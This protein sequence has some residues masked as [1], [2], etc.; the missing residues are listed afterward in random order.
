MRRFPFPHAK[1]IPHIPW[2]VIDKPPE[3]YDEVDRVLVWQDYGDVHGPF[4]CQPERRAGLLVLADA[5]LET[6]DPRAPAFAAAMH[7]SHYICVT[8]APNMEGEP[9]PGV[10]RKD[11]LQVLYPGKMG[12]AHVPTLFVQGVGSAALPMRDVIDRLFCAWSPT[13]WATRVIPGAIAGVWYVKLYEE[14]EELAPNGSVLW[15]FVAWQDRA[16]R[17]F[18]LQSIPLHRDQ[19]EQTLRWGRRHRSRYRSV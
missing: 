12:R 8:G 14:L 11:T 7:Y 5:L 1:E 17:R 3:E 10:L 9:V 18:I 19:E 6:E 16:M 2:V 13:A 15:S 4:V